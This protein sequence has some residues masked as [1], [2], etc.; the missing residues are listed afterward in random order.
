MDVLW[1]RP[2]EARVT[3]GTEI[4]RL[5]KEGD[6]RW[7]ELVPLSVKDYILKNDLHERLC[8]EVVR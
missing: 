6:H 4:R 8:F 1:E 3:S 5:I 7:E 2:M